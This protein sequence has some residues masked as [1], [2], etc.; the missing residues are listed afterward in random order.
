MVS[1]WKMVSPS[2]RIRMSLPASAMPRFSAPAFPELGWLMTR[3]YGMRRPRAMA[4]VDDDD[5]DLAAVTAGHHGPDGGGDAR[6]LVV[7]GD[8]HRN[9]RVVTDCGP[10]GRKP[11]TVRP[12]EPDEQDQPDHGERARRQQDRRQH[13]DGAV[14]GL[15]GEHERGPGE[16]LTAG[17]GHVT[18]R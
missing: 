15:L 9:V 17:G 8:H 7:R 6:R 13:G 16:P 1:A 18:G 11:A 3:T 14:G 4:V 2:T 10:D 12:G 5:L